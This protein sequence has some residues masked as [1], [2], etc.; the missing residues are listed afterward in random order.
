MAQ[1]VIISRKTHKILINLIVFL[2]SILLSLIIVE[3]ILK[4]FYPFNLKTIGGTDCKNAQLYGW[5][6]IT[7]V[8]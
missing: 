3:T 8:N 2:I 7:E 1:K 4:I 6:Y 5:G